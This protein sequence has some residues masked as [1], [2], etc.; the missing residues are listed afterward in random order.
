MEC[1]YV[2][3]SFA[4][5]Y[6][7]QTVPF[8]ISLFIWELFQRLPSE[9]SVGLQEDASSKQ[10]INPSLSHTMP[11]HSRLVHFLLLLAD[12]FAFLWVVFR[13]LGQ[14]HRRRLHHA[15]LS[16]PQSPTVGFWLMN[17][18][19]WRFCLNPPNYFHLPFIIPSLSSSPLTRRSL[20]SP[21]RTSDQIPSLL[22]LL[23]KAPESART[24]KVTNMDTWTMLH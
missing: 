6:S 14:N 15:I 16:P 9:S 4:F 10:D 21:R 8:C 17:R 23:G 7:A 5:W 1:I 22:P 19:H 3:V 11:W 24:A 12:N 2:Y 13:D 20:L 18:R